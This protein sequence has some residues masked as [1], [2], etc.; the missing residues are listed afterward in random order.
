MVG[1]AFNPSQDNKVDRIKEKAA[2]L[3]DEIHDQ[4]NEA[5][6][7]R[8][9]DQFHSE[10]IKNIVTGVMWAVKGTTWKD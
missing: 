9:S 4:S 5:G 3:L 8:P 6:R 7:T 1:V 10:G 2:A